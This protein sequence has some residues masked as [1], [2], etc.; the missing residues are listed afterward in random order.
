MRGKTVADVLLMLKAELGDDLSTSNEDLRYM[1]LLYL[2]QQ[3]LAT[4]FD[5][6]FLQLKAGEADVVAAPTSRYLV[7][8]NINLD[9]P[10]RAEVFYNDYWQCVDYGIN[11]DEYNLYRSEFGEKQDPIQR[12]QEIDETVDV[13]GI[14]YQKFEI[15]P[16][17]SVQQT[18]RFWGQRALHAFEDDQD[19]CDLDDLLLVLSVALPILAKRESPSATMVAKRLDERL[20]LLKATNPVRDEKLVLGKQRKRLRGTP[21]KIVAIHS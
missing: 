4:S 3:E 14:Q 18:V 19:E 5:W 20:K 13:D 11:S 12:W 17:P 9:R 1:Q 7:L 21:I 10:V 15:W 16:I 8:P 6:P 2:A